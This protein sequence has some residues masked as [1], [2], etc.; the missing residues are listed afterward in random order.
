VIKR[1]ADNDILLTVSMARQ[2]CMGRI[3]TYADYPLRH[4]YDEEVKLTLTSHMPT[5]YKSTLCDEYLALVEHND[6]TVEELEELAMNSVRYS[7]LPED[8]KVQMQKSFSESFAQLR[9][10]HL[11][12][13][14]PE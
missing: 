5:F 1:L 7:F 14:T 13:E 10:E 12:Q 11:G 2:L 3:A 6:F 8:E 9:T 4:V